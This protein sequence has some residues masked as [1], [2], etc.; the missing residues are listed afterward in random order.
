MDSRDRS[1]REPQSLEAWDTWVDRLIVEAQERGDFDNL[2]GQ[3]K[4]LHIEESPFADGRELGFGILKNAG[5]A[6][7]W[8]ELEKEIRTT[9]ARTDDLLARAARLAQERRTRRQEEGPIP[10][11][12]LRWWWPFGRRGERLRAEPAPAVDPVASEIARLRREFLELAAERERLLGQYNAAIP[13]E[14]W[15]LERPRRSPDDYAREFDAAVHAE[16]GG[17]S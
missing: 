12:S 10:E 9:S 15:H 7:Y 5:F 17:P 16:S 11:V 2:P 1:K 8:V 13:R 4:P 6:P 14:L 3:G